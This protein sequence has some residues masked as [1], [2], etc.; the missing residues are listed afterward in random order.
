MQFP[1]MLSVSS[2]HVASFYYSIR[3]KKN[4]YII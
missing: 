4:V 3:K 1:E 2:K